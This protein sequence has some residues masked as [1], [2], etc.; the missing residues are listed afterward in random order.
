MEAFLLKRNDVLP[1]VNYEFDLEF[2][3]RI[4]SFFKDITQSPLE[5]EIKLLDDEDYVKAFG[6][7]TTSILVNAR[8]EG[9]TKSKNYFEVS[10]HA[11]DEIHVRVISNKIALSSVIH[12]FLHSLYPELAEK[13]LDYATSIF[14]LTF[15]TYEKLLKNRDLKD[16]FI[17]L[18][19]HNRSLLSLSK[20]PLKL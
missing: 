5:I 14:E 13:K 3:K 20:L 8:T 1:P 17:E 15:R 7:N 4:K 9:E 10:E 6:E 11:T 2:G 12:E 19:T 16:F 18:C